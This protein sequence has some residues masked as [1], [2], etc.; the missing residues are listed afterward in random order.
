MIEHKIDAAVRGAMGSLEV[1]KELKHQF[2]LKDVH[3]T[4]ILENGSGTQFLLTPVGIDEGRSLTQRIELVKSTIE[5]FAAVGWKLKVGVLSKGRPEDA[6]RG[7]EI[8]RS[9]DVGESM[10]KRLN[11]MGISAKHYSILLE[12]SV[13]EADLV[14]A[15]DG[16]TGNLI[17]RSLH[18][19]GR[20]KA[21]GAPVVNIP[22]VFV[23]TSRS[24]AD[25]SDAILLAA[26][27]A[28]AQHGVKQ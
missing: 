19:V 8:R 26:G 24:K 21:Y 16:V 10:T 1:L 9:L 28:A 27:L 4:A 18:F 6:S 15:P 12:E 5:Y 17:F 14:V 13:R 7:R 25:F 11:A 20:G 3:R 22:E 23:D 2:Q